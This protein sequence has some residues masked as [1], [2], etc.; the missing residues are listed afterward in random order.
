M[1][2][3]IYSIFII[4][5]LL[6]SKG[7]LHA[8]NNL[9]FEQANKAYQE[10]KYEE[11]IELYLDIVD[12][13]N[14]G[15][16]LFYNLGNACFKSGENAKA[17]LWYERALRKAPSNE[18]IK[19]NIAFVNQH[20]TD[21]IEVMPDFIVVRWWNAISMSLTANSWAITS[22]IL[23]F[24]VAIGLIIMLISTRQWLRS[25]G[26][27]FALLTTIILI[28]SIIFA[29]NEN[30][31]YKNEPVAIIMNSVVNVKSTPNESGSDL[32]IIHKGLKVTITDSLNEWYEIKIP[33]GEKGW[34]TKTSLEII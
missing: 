26:F 19:H 14:E 17:L 16:M 34:I 21:K 13:G 5:I 1:K 8:D 32:F 22:I 15:A 25:S 20:I 28:F 30:I 31:R 2:S 9:L 4:S 23:S 29:H 24:L 33:N 12:K 18:D 6:I 3:T 10:Q 7:Y 11:A 27:V